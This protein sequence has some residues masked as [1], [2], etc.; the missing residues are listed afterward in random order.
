MA[1]DSSLGEAHAARGWSEYCEFNWQ[2]GEKELQEAIR[3]SPNYAMGYCL[4]AL[5]LNTEGKCHHV[6]PKASRG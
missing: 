3:L 2:A 4:D 6:L 1:I 5:I